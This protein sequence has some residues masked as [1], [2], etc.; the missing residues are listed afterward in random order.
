M[1]HNHVSY[2]YPQETFSL[3]LLAVSYIANEALD[4]LLVAQAGHNRFLE[5]VEETDIPA[6]YFFFSSNFI[7]SGYMLS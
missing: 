7:L 6:Q 5:N 1:T 4:T 2:S 3:S